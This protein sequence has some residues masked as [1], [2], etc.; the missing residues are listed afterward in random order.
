MLAFLGPTFERYGRGRFR[1]Q[2]SA[3]RASIQDKATGALVRVLGSGPRRLHGAA[4]S[5]TRPGRTT[6]LS[7]GG[8]GSERTPD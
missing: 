6:R 4:P 3:N 8:P 1:V 7:S 2:D 5:P